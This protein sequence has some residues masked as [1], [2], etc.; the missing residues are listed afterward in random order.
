M[1]GQIALPI[2]LAGLACTGTEESLLHCNKNMY[3]LLGCY[4][5]ELA[6]VECE[7]THVHSHQSIILCTELCINDEIRIVGSPIPSIGRVEVCVNRTW[8]TICDTTWNEAAAS[9]VCYNQGYSLYGMCK[10]IMF[11]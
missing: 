11:I 3:G 1:Y 7:G 5:S 2:M 10:C 9:L 4:N 6:G 8:G